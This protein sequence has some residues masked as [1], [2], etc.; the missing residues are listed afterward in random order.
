MALNEKLYWIIAV[1]P[2][3]DNFVTLKRKVNEENRYCE[4]NYFKIPSLKVGTLDTLMQL[5]EDL[6]KVDSFVEQVTKKIGR[7]ALEI[8]RESKKSY[9]EKTISDLNFQVNDTSL[10]SFI[11]RFRWE[12]AKY[13]T[14]T[15]MREV[16]DTIQ[17][18]VN[19]LDEELKVKMSEYTNLRTQR[20]AVER[21]AGGNLMLK[22]LAEFVHDTDVTESENITTLFAVIPGYLEKEWLSSYAKLLEGQITDQDIKNEKKDQEK[23]KPKRSKKEQEAQDKL[24]KE[25]KDKLE[26]EEKDKLTKEEK[27][28]LEKE[29]KEEKRLLE[30]EKKN[31]KN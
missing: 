27:D 19:K 20:T 5:S 1:P 30:E 7:Q 10:D 6:V 23:D 11:T 24:T 9:D 25:E 22:D 15:P 21:K 18:S 14:Q 26:K 17:A 4:I 29:E 8:D 2:T 28:R 3:N 12:D 13:S 31:G 16:A